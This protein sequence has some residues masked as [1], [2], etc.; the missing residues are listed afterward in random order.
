LLCFFW[1]EFHSSSLPSSFF[2][3]FL[4]KSIISLCCCCCWRNEIYLKVFSCNFFVAMKL[5][6]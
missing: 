3:S 1:N 4:V 5:N 2:L 6:S